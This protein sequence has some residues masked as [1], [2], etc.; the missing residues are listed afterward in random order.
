MLGKSMNFAILRTPFVFLSKFEFKSNKF[1]VGVHS[2]VPNFPIWV[3]ITQYF[4]I[5]T[6][7][8]CCFRYRNI[9]PLLC[10]PNFAL[11]NT[12]KKQKMN[13]GFATVR[14]TIETPTIRCAWTLTNGNPYPSNALRTIPRKTLLFFSLLN[15]IMKIYYFSMRKVQICIY[16][17]V[18]YLKFL[19]L[20]GRYTFIDV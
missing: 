2:R 16:F 10:L 13:H 9:I 15:L 20:K 3:L 14:F 1:F 18:A 12:Y 19:F 8:P 17:G 11:L 6:F 4:P 7:S 5:S